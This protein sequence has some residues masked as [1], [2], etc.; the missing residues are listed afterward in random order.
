MSCF[1]FFLSSKFVKFGSNIVIAFCI[2]SNDIVTMPH[3]EFQSE[4][5]L[6]RKKIIGSVSKLLDVRYEQVDRLNPKKS[7]K[8]AVFVFIVAAAD[9]SECNH[10]KQRMMQSVQDEGLSKVRHICIINS[11]IES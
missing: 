7:S 8:G 11:K 9:V 10:V 3:K 2:E 1:E 4:I 5:V 6:R